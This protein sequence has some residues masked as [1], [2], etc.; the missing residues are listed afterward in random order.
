MHHDIAAHQIQI[1]S[2]IQPKHILSMFKMIAKGWAPGNIVP[3]IMF[4]Q[5]RRLL[6]RWNKLPIPIPSKMLD[7]IEAHVDKQKQYYRYQ[8]PGP[9]TKIR[10]DA[11]REQA[12]NGIKFLPKTPKPCAAIAIHAKNQSKEI[13]QDMCTNKVHA[14][15]GRLCNNWT[16]RSHGYT[17][18]KKDPQDTNISVFCMECCDDLELPMNKSSTCLCCTSPIADTFAQAAGPITGPAPRQ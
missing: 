3:V 2:Q 10:L 4:L 12:S 1:Q 11:L 8:N 14:C 17:T 7:I 18:T 5:K 15:I 9:L 16:C 6:A 13:I